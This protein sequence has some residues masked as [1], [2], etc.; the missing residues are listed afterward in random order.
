MILLKKMCFGLFDLKR[1]LMILKPLL[2]VLL[3]RSIV[4]VSFMLILSNRGKILMPQI[5]PLVAYV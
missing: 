3:V 1:L 2:R 5:G 4:T